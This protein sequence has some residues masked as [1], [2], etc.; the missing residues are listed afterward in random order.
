VIDLKSN[1]SHIRT[2]MMSVTIIM[3][4]MI[5]LAAATLAACGGGAQTTDNPITS[6]PP[7][8]NYNGPPPQTT[9]I[10]NFKLNVWDNIQA[11][12]RCGSCH[13]QG[14]QGGNPFVRNDDINLAFEAA[15]TVADLGQ[16]SDSMLVTRVGGGHNCWIGDT[17][18]CADIMTTW[19]ENWA[20]AT[21]GG[22]REIVLNPPAKLPPGASKN[23][24]PSQLASFGTTVHPVLTT[25]CQG[26]H[27]SQ[28]AAAQQPY[29]A[30]ADVAVAFDAD[31]PKMDL[32]EP[33]DSRLV[34]RLRAEFHNCWPVGCAAS[35]DVMQTAIEAFAGPILPTQVDPALVFSD[36]LRIIDGKIASGGNRYENAQISLL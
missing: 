23:Y 17:Q 10:Q 3:R 12:N 35:A 34:I 19:I 8:S 11:T 18:A 1:S 25:Y 27:T 2:S 29:F 9:D 4:M 21:A 32:A 6:V 15:N 16:P 26:C 33:A 13:A 28:S 20:G 5:L 24:D 7:Q 14:G 31:K 22:G 30:E 36:A